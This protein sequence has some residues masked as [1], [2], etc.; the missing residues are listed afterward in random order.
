MPVDLVVEAMDEAMLSTSSASSRAGSAS[1]EHSRVS[2]WLNQDRRRSL[3]TAWQALWW[4]R[5]VVW[6]SGLVAIA[7]VGTK[8]TSAARFDAPGLTRPFGAF[9]DAI[10]GPAARWDSHWFLTIADEGYGGEPQRAAFF[11]LYP[12]LVRVLGALGS[13]LVAGIAVSMVATFAALYLLDRLATL[14]LGPEAARRSVLL[15]AFFPTALF[16]SAVYA[17][18]LFLALAV[19]TMY[20]GR[21]QRWALAGVCGM[22]AAATRS[23]GLLLLVPL[24]V[25]YLYGPREDEVRARGET[26]ARGEPGAREKPGARR[27]TGRAAPWRPR[28]PVRGDVL[29]LGLVPL[30]LAAYLLFL[31]H[32]IG[33]AFAPFA[34]EA[35]WKRHFTGPLGG[36][37]EGT[38]A[39]AD[40]LR[41]L[42]TGDR[43]DTWLQIVGND[44]PVPRYNLLQYAFLLVA[45]PATIGVLRR[46][47]AA[48]GA[49]TLVM[50]ALP[51]SYPSGSQPLISL[52]RFVLVIFPFFMWLAL[53]TH[54][55]RLD[56]WALGASAL[57]LALFSVQFSTWEWVG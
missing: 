31:Q 7:A 6:A 1:P 44:V 29:W 47:P 19:G 45:I 34:A 37:W 54:E 50:L 20:F 21:T 38:V 10:V 40:A 55:R 25:L 9:G 57:L 41:A 22:L 23:S 28:Y 8:E 14:E 56:R 16:L 17:E 33:D 39:A 11:P 26:D 49:Y 32:S 27:G 52:S 3:R 13:P 2:A 35:A 15:L 43:A 4:S 30:G 18:A 5:A 12:L 36:V 53:W 46:L 42:I 24:A 48:Y 51:L